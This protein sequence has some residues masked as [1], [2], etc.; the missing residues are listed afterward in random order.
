MTTHLQ[1]QREAM[2]VSKQKG[3]GATFASPMSAYK[4]FLA[5]IR[6]RGIIGA[7]QDDIF[8]QTLI[9]LQR[10]GSDLNQNFPVADFFQSAKRELVDHLRKTG[11]RR[12]QY[13]P[14]FSENFDVS[15]DSHKS[16]P[17][18][19]ERLDQLV[20]GLSF[21]EQQLLVHKFGLGLSDE[22]LANDL[23]ITRAAIYKQRKKVLARLRRGLCTAEIR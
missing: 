22:V 19:W 7:T 9:R 17:D 1:R 3:K 4:P 21:S 18:L 5:W 13:I 6:R 8:Q 23:G 12:E 15:I 14:D 20:K 10:E 11:R 2:P 16:F